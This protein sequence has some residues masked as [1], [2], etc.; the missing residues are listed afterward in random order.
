MEGDA[1]GTHPPCTPVAKCSVHF[2]FEER[3]E[4]EKM[5]QKC[6]CRRLIDLLQKLSKIR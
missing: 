5:K 4:G 1:R 6:N 3:A 2:A